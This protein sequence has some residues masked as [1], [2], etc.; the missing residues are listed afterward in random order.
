MAAGDQGGMDMEM[1][2]CMSGPSE[3]ACSPIFNALGIAWKDG[4]GGGAA[5]AA[6]QTVFRAIAR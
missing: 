6:R 3:T 2:G 4:S 5:S 1:S